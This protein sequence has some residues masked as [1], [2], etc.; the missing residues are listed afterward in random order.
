M[1]R[2]AKRLTRIVV[3]RGAA[4]GVVVLVYWF[5]EEVA[6]LALENDVAALFL[7]ASIFALPVIVLL[8]AA[9]RDGA[10]IDS[11]PNPRQRRDR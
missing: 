1:Q 2:A 3:S 4:I 11:R 6:G 8:Y 10:K 9:W 7:G 5:G